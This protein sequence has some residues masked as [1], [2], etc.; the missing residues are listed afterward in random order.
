MT[1]TIYYTMYTAAVRGRVGVPRCISMSTQ[2]RHCLPLWTGLDKSFQFVS[3]HQEF[4]NNEGEEYQAD[5][6]SPTAQN[7]PEVYILPLTEV[8]LPVSKQ[9]G[10]SSKTQHRQHV[11][12]LTICST[13]FCFLLF[14]QCLFQSLQ[15]V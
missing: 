4:D 13:L 6:A 12:P 15:T 11:T 10:R 3:L 9:P 5:L 1:H 2:R 14:F 8:S 7:G